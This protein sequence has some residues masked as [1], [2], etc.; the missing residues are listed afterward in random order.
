MLMSYP[1]TGGRKFAAVAL[2][3]A[4]ACVTG[5][6][7]AQSRTDRHIATAKQTAV[8][9]W[10]GAQDVAIYALG[11]IGID[12]KYG[13]ETPENGLD[14]SGLV[15]YVFQQVTGV[16]LPRTSKELSLIGAKVSP[17]D[18]KV[19]DLVFFNTRRLAY[20]HVGIY[21]GD[22]RFIHAPNTGSEVEIAKLSESYWQKHFN[23]AR[24]L[25]GVLPTLVPPVVTTAS[26]ATFPAGAT[27]STPPGEQEIAAAAFS[28]P[29][30]ATPAVPLPAP[31]EP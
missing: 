1:R 28:A 10:Q 12:Y 21:L 26:A 27:L 13:G 29:H 22:N 9:V 14:C 19:G 18:L 4:A 8:N 23:G 20:S 3:A 15:R 24:R 2:I 30:G 17:D 31:L 25:V 16:T 11:M 7:N 5:A 6:A